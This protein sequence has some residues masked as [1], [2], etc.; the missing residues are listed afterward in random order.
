M[1]LTVNGKIFDFVAHWHETIEV[2]GG[3]KGLGVLVIILLG[4]YLLVEFT[5]LHSRK[6]R[7]LARKRI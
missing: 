5:V 1:K 2:L 6:R 3:Y 7:N 4:F